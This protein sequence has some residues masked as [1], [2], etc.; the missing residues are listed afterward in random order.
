MITNGSQLKTILDLLSN[1]LSEGWLYYFCAKSLNDAY[2]KHRINSA[3][4]FFMSSFSASLNESILTL[5]KLMINHPDS[6]SI[7]YLLN[8]AQNNPS[9]LKFATPDKIK[10]ATKDHRLKLDNYNSLLDN[11]RFQRDKVLAHLDRKH[12]NDPD[13]I[14]SNPPLDMNEVEVCYKELHRILNDYNQYFNKSEFYLKNIEEEVNEDIEF[15]LSLI[16]KA[17]NR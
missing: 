8:Y 17:D 5:S 12:V 11:I 1:Q 4:F 3:R 7:Y 14:L 15:L 13:F 2:Q 10:Q 6:I 16:E 9:E